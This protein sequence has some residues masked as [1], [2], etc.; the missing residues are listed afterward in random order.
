M[1]QP[2][3]A[4][5]PPIDPAAFRAAMRAMASCV[6]VVTAG[7]AGNRVGV[8][9]TAVSSLSDQPAMMLA[10]VNRLSSALP[11]IRN[12]GHFC[13]N[14]LSRSQDDVAEIFAGRTGLRGDA[15]FGRHEWLHLETGAPV[16]ALGLVAFDCR[17]AEVHEAATHSVLFGEVC[18]LH[19]NSPSEPLLYAAGQFRGLAAV[20]TA[21]RS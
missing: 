2:S 8:T 16:L 18:A 6:A 1:I 19:E 14:F 21:S 5:P 7:E 4:N 20:N 12:A 17:L 10:C 13:I 3:E 15:R 11:I 9:V